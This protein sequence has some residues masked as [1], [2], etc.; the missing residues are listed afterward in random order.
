VFVYDLAANEV[1]AE[2]HWTGP[3]AHRVALSPD[4]NLVAA[5]AGPTVRV[6]NVESKQA[7]AEMRVGKKHLMGLA[8]S[9]DGRYLAAV[10]GDRMT[11]FWQVGAWGEPRTF[12]WNVGKLR[13]VAFSPDG[14]TAAVA[15]DKG[16]IVIFDVD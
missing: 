4:G 14:A 6:W 2:F 13:D 1:I 7:V 5:S 11:R 12:E 9:P 15:S 10:S 8:F 3:I 16:Q